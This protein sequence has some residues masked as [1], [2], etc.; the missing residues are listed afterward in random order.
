MAR[1]PAG[2]QL[3]VR[4]AA[5]RRSMA[6]AAWA[7]PVSRA[8]RTAFPIRRRGSR[9]TYS[10]RLRFR[11]AKHHRDTL[12]QLRGAERLRHQRGAEPARFAQNAILAFGGEDQ[13][14]KTGGAALFAQ[15]TQEIEAGAVGQMEV[16]QQAVGRRIRPQRA[17]GFIERARE[18]HAVAELLEIGAQDEPD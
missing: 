9:P 10:R 7:V 15:V 1:V 6:A 13:D 11:I 17:A 2:A 8:A 3:T 4:A 14:G 12:A 18:G 16:E 5:G